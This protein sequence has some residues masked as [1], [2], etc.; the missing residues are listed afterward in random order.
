MTG[1]RHRLILLLYLLALVFLGLFWRGGDLLSDWGRIIQA[2]SVLIT[3]Y[4]TLAGPGAAL[5]N[6]GVVGLIG[7]G[8]LTVVGTQIS[9]G[10][11]A[12]M[13]TM[14]GFAFF[15]KT[16]LN[17]L[18][19]FLG[20]YLFSLA[21]QSR[22]QSY[23]LVAM[24]GTSLGPLVS[25]V[26]FGLGAHWFWGLAAGAAAG[27]VL[28][29]L[30]PHLLHNHQ[31]YNLYSTGFAAGIVGMF[32][33][34]LLKSFGY[35]STPV[36]CWSSEYSS[37]L[38][39]FF[40][41]YFISMIVLG[42][43]GGATIGKLKSLMQFPGAMVTD[44]TIQ[45]DH[46]T[47]FANMGLLGLVGLAYCYLVSGTLNG[48]LLGGILTM[49]GFAAFGKH[50]RNSIPIMLGVYLAT[51][52]QVSAPADPGPMLA[53]LFGTSLAPLAGAFGPIVGLVA[54]F[55]QLSVVSHVGVMHG[56]L[57]LYNHGLAAGF[58]A[59][60]MVVMIRTFTEKR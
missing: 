37:A 4:F 56:G 60:L 50:P 17:V 58:V 47:T 35:T 18:P 40:A 16:P 54:G 19:I 25:H 20:V 52:L 13:F 57:N 44:F 32:A 12:A 55:L 42:W 14:T 1:H 3:D 45:V 34:A 30:A 24:F 49:V 2:P 21:K 11:I 31:G 6:A 46:A 9:G 59:T 10:A 27:F 8:L 41:L 15:G 36:L 5:V 51:F 33:L 7:L 39:A 28:P 29:A 53:A 48:P 23:I 26:T 22:F 38:F 43:A